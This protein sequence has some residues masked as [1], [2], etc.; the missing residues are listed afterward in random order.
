MGLNNNNEEEKEIKNEK[1]NKAENE[2]TYKVITNTKSQKQKT[3]K[4]AIIIFLVLFILTMFCTGFA[5]LNINNTKII[6]GVKV[7]GIEIKGLTVEEAKNI[8]KEKLDENLSKDILVKSNG[9][10]YTFRLNQIE[11]NYEIEEAVNNAYLVGRNGNIISNNFE[12]LGS[13]ISGK[14]IDVEFSYNEELLNSLITDM[15]SKVPEAV[16]EADYYIEEDKLI[17]T[18]GKP[19]NSIDKENLK[20]KIIDRLKNND[21]TE[22]ELQILYIQPQQIDIDKIH[23]EV[24]TEPKDAYYTE[25]PFQVYSHQNGIDFDLE[26]AREALKEDKE[27]YEIDLKITTPQVTTDQ[28][29]TAAFPNLISTFTTRYD[30]SNVPRS[31]NLKL[32]MQKLDGYV[33]NPG[34]TFSYNKALGKRTAEGG[35][36]LAGGF[37]GGKVVQTLAGGI[38]QISSTLYDAAVYANLEII[39]RHNHMFLTGYVGAGKDATVVYGSLDFKFKNTRNYPI[40]IK[41]NIGGGVAKID[42]YGVKENIEYEVEIVTKVLSY[43]PYKVVY[44]QDNSLQPGQQKVTQ[45]GLNGCKSITYKVLKQNGVEVSRTVLSTDYYDPLNT[46]IKVG[47]QQNITPEPEPNTE[48]N[49]EPTPTPEPEPESTPDPTPTPEPDPEPIPDPTPEPE[50]DPEPIPDSTPI[51]ESKPEPIPDI[52]QE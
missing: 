46:I 28:I 48:P 41:T 10:E 8:I 15:Q 23:S 43:T 31:T 45:N 50:P 38:C 17:I 36:K 6:S 19:G 24:Y 51:P 20:N 21:N 16:V 27:Q 34:E 30:A 14:N 32:A 37:A 39:E 2:Q 42:I 12:I 33:V 13:M 47:P 18:K 5:L 35:Y 26:V 52:E 11:A 44:E 9:F 4:I 29:G 3:L 1:E 22:I 49:T 7:K 40:M 25:E